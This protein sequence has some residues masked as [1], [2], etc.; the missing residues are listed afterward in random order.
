M[1][2][3]TVS[4]GRMVMREDLSVSEAGDNRTMALAGQESVPRL[5]P[6]F[7][8]SRREDFL[9]L[10]G[11]IVPVV[12]T[13]KDYLNGFYQIETTSGSIE[14]WDD[15][16]I[17]VF[18]WSC[19]LVRLG[20][21]SEVDIESRLSGS[22]T[23]V[24]N[25]SVVGERTHAP[26]IGHDSY[27]SDA[28][29]S[30]VLT[31]TAEDGALKLYRGLGAT[32]SP[33]WA[34]TPELYAGGRVRFLDANGGERAGTAF[35]CDPVDWELSNG[36]V[37]VR[38]GAALE[39]AAWTGGSWKP[40]VWDVR[41]GGST[42]A[43][44]THCALIDNRYESATVRLTKSQATGRTFVDLKLRRGSR[45]VEIYIQSEFGT[46]L[47]IQRGSVEAGTSALAGTVVANAN[48]PDNKYI[49]GS[50]RTFNPD[51]VNGA[52]EKAATTTLDAFVGVIA[53]GTGA[54]VGDQAADL[55]KQY[56]GAPSELVQVVRR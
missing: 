34:V 51:I 14:D 40:K 44:F 21:V 15:G 19:T 2:R 5:S 16:A 48:D 49:I 13:T 53:G 52:I 39:I 35:K 54:A 37:R 17:R 1:P 25:F 36:L 41:A 45:F 22:I 7:I 46:T 18:R 27:W 38:P 28:T 9:A 3:P 31:R 4:I 30:S 43:P 29:I 11:Q 42:L 32:V 50:A 33:R 24:N 20:T 26:A 55:Q 23:R 12:F 6:E 8:V 47:R 56:I 10:D